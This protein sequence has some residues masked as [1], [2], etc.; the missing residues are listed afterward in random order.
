MVGIGRAQREAV[1]KLEGILFPNSPRARMRTAK[2]LND[3]NEIRE[4]PACHAAHH[5]DGSEA[6]RPRM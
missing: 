4:H 6:T 3:C 5:I 2:K 1:A